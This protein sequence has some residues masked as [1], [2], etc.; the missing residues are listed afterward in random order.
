MILLILFLI[1]WLGLSIR[2]CWYILIIPLIL[3]F[4]LIIKQRKP[5]LMIISSLMLLM[6]LVSSNIHINTNSLT[7]QGIVYEVKENYYLFNSSGE[8]FYVYEKNNTREIGD[9]IV[10]QGEKVN[11]EFETLESSFNFTEYLNKKGVFSQL[12]PKKVTVKFSC[13]LKLQAAKR[14]FLSGFQGD[15]KALISSILFSMNDD[16]SIN[17]SIRSLHLG[18]FIS[19]NGTYIYLFLGFLSY[20]LSLF[21]PKKWADVGS[22]AIVNIYLIFVFTKF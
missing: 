9:I 13:P 19:A 20:I 4:W 22:L 11:L 14:S 21:L 7:H 16:S 3:L 15:T 18:K 2:C 8:R 6:G 12:N 10:I 1:Y 17:T 5:K